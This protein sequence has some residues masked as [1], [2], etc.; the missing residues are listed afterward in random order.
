[1]YRIGVDIGGTKINLGIFDYEKKSLIASKKCYIKDIKSLAEYIKESV[2]ELSAE[3]GI[4]ADGISACGV[5]IQ[6][7]RAHV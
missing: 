1:M 5:G 2:L 7:G 3:N 4:S 6:I